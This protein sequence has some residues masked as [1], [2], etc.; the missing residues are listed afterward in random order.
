[1]ARF[2]KGN[3]GGP[4]RPKRQTEA[5]YLSVMMAA[6]S[7]ETWRDIVDAAVTHAKAGDPAARAWLGRYLMGE[8]ATKA[9][10]PTTVI[11][12]QV[13]DQTPGAVDPVLTHALAQALALEN[14]PIM[15]LDDTMERARAML[16]A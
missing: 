5:A 2:E 14:D 15:V 16:E 11:V 3:A 12:Q 4:G 13:I 1:M 8:P 7:L 6:C 10:A 9:P